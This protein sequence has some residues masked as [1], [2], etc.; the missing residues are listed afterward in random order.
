MT[1]LKALINSAASGENLV[2]TGPHYQWIERLETD[3][4]PSPK[5]VAHA[6][7]AYLRLYKHPRAGRF[8]ASAM[9]GCRR[10]TIF[11]YAN[12]PQVITE[13]AGEEIFNHGTVSHLRWQMEGLTM[14]YMTGAE[15]WVE[16]KDLLVGGSLDA[17][18][19]NGDV[20][21]LKSAAPSV[22]R[23]IV[24]EA[25]WPKAQNIAQADA[26]M[27]L[28]DAPF[29]SLVYEDRSYGDFHE[30]RVERD[31]QRERALLR[32]LR[33]LRRYVEED[34]L[35]QMLDDCELRLGKVYR[36]CYFREICPKVNTVNDAV[37]A[38][39]K[40]KTEDSGL[41]VAP[42][43]DVPKWVTHV[44]AVLDQAVPHG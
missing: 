3:Q 44:L 37:E 7:R 27:L 18:L 25:R 20:F 32:E 42:G 9:G 19:E 16:D 30:F 24:E 23:R 14:G 11:G 33:T 31:A 13:T 35:P 12:A 40:A 41:Q 6:I 36:N 34:D 17:V 43:E 39:L 2:V 8:S 29:T 15:V 4:V 21:E 38:G 26:Y 1:S 22:Y 5:A 28:K 10:A